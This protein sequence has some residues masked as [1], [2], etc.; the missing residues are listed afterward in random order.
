MYIC[1]YI[2]ILLITHFATENHRSDGLFPV[3]YLS[4]SALWVI[5]I[6]NK[7]VTVSVRGMLNL[8]TLCVKAEHNL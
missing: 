3:I 7:C 6:M 8:K 4:D 5:A 1:V 2:S